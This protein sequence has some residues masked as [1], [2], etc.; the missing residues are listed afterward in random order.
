MPWCVKGG[1]SAP[2]G[3][4][5]LANGG[6]AGERAAGGWRLDRFDGWLPVRSLFLASPPPAAAP[7][8]GVLPPRPTPLRTHLPR[9][10][11]P[12]ALQPTTN[13]Q[14]RVRQVGFT[15]P[16]QLECEEIRLLDPELKV[17][18]PLCCGLVHTIVLAR[19]GRTPGRAK[20]GRAN[21]G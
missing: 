9:L 12:S 6:R 5:L 3:L 16:R 19:A 10:L 8:P 7:F 18:G 11:P 4:G 1:G 14:R 21:S 13:R 2:W 15:D 17:G 20:S